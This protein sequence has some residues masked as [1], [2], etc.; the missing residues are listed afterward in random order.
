M[1]VTVTH[2][3]NC[4][5]SDGPA[6][7]V[8]RPSDWN[9]SHTLAGIGTMAEQA[10][11][12]VA[13]TGGTIA[14]VTTIGLS[15]HLTFSSTGQRILGDFNNATVA[16]RMLFQ[17]SATGGT[18]SVGAIPNG[19]ATSSVFHVFNSSDTANAAIAQMMIDTNS[20]TLG[21]YKTGSGAYLPML[22][23]VN[24]NERV[25]FETNG[26]VG[27][28]TTVPRS[29]LDVL[30]GNTTFPWIRNSVG[31]GGTAFA[32]TDTIPI[33][34]GYGMVGYSG[35][36]ITPSRW[37]N[38]TTV[39]AHTNL[40]LA[41]T[42][43]NVGGY[44]T[45]ITFANWGYFTGTTTAAGGLGN[46]TAQSDAVKFVISLKDG[47]SEFS[48]A[49]YISTKGAS[50]AGL[51]ATN[52]MIF[53]Q[54]GQ[55]GFGVYP[56]QYLHMK[57][58]YNLAW[59][60]ASN[61]YTSGTAGASIMKYSDNAM[62]FDNFDGNTYFRGSGYAVSLKI[63][64]DGSTEFLGIPKFSGGV[65]TTEGGEIHFANPASGSALGGTFV[66]QDINTNSVRFMEGGGSVRGANLDLSTCG[67]SCSSVIWHSGN[68]GHN[69]GLD[70]DSVDGYQGSALS[71]LVSFANYTTTSIES[72]LTQRYNVT[73]GPH[74]AT[75]Y[76][77]GIHSLLFSDTNY[78]WE[79]VSPS[80]VAGNHFYVRQKSGGS[81]SGTWDKLALQKRV[82]STNANYT[83]IAFDHVWQWGS[84]TTVTLPASPNIGD[85]VSVTPYFTN[86]VVARNAQ[87]IMRLA[88]DMTL[89]VVYATVTFKYL[90]S[91]QGWNL[92]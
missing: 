38:A 72:G 7:G 54:N 8:V 73:G 56:S 26:Y 19:S 92:I 25:R 27:I 81:F 13:I 90:D 57:N 4:A 91:S 36:A 65:G 77:C 79:M 12:S 37:G 44:V 23:V 10:A 78:G 89:D 3:F 67:A 30:C 47:G 58:T 75:N 63:F 62:Y 32:N 18:T 1:A 2:A 6:T 66:I 28:N 85:E 71:K 34:S 45:G 69:S 80:A 17:S 41:G 16:N 9:A 60:N 11:S 46:S 43:R 24:N 84:A 48:H 87:P 53:N 88:E 52:S 39:D 59:D 51:P 22:F 5:I 82:V 61:T 31:A 14:G 64:T 20:M 76:H 74:P 21:A 40:Y 49:L 50:S 86:I 29:Y 55:I 15:S 70:A 83:A 68:D 35:L 33:A 42:Q